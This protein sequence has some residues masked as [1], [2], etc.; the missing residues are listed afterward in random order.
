MLLNLYTAYIIRT[1]AAISGLL[2][3]GKNVSNFLYADDT[4][5]MADSGVKLQQLSKAV[6]EEVEKYGMKVNIR[7]TKSMVI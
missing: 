4:V 5:L 1:I 3:G 6:N 7:K 2:I